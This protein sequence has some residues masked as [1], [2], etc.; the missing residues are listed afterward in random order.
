M[1]RMQQLLEQSLLRL[2][3]ARH[4]QAEPLHAQ[5]VG[6]RS[7]D[8]SGQQSA[9]TTHVPPGATLHVGGIGLHAVPLELHV[10]PAAQLPHR[11]DPPAPQVSGPHTRPAH[12]H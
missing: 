10:Y 8:V 5:A 6:L 7:P 9:S 12:E 4:V 1:R 11:A 3:S 2:Q